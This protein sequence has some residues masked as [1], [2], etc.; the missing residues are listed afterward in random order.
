[1]SS[2]IAGKTVWETVRDMEDRIA[3]L[4]RE[5]RRLQAALEAQGAE[6]MS[7]NLILGDRLGLPPREAL[8]LDALRTARG[9]GAVSR[10]ALE[11]AAEIRGGSRT[12]AYVS[13]SRLRAVLRRELG[14]SLHGL[15]PI[16]CEARHGWRLCGVVRAHV[17][18]LVQL[19]PL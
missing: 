6:S 11:R 14:D 17:E 4:T 15:D 5:N 13:L 9:A 18:R 1:M 16:P 12:A 8:V 7:A 3:V 19:G 10:A 2:P